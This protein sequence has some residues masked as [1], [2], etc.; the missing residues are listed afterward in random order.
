[1]IV[2]DKFI[3]ETVEKLKNHY[4]I[5]TGNKFVRVYLFGTRIPKNDLMNMEDLLDSVQAHET[6]S[7]D[8]NGLYEKIYSF[9]GV[10]KKI[11]EEILPRM[12][13]E[14]DGKMKNLPPD[15]KILY[16]MTLDNIPGNL[17]TFYALLGELYSRT[18]RV[19]TEK[20]GAE[21]YY[22]SLPFFKDIEKKLF[23][24]LT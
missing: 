8:L 10:V 13:S 17:Q 22:K 14:K 19:D 24:W 21:A 20:N 5:F 15:D 1:M 12:K 4:T 18:K 16:R 23:T 7:F 9:V 11:E 2:K 6:A 3:N